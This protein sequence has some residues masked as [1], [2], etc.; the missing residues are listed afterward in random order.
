MSEE[1]K[2]IV[3][4]WHDV[5]DYSDNDLTN[6]LRSYKFDIL[7][8]LSGFTTG[9]RF[10]VLARRCAKIQIEWLG[11]NNSLGAKNIDYLITDKNLIK[12]D[13]HKFYKEKI[14]YLPNIWN[15]SLLQLN[16]LILKRK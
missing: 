3:Y 1:L 4:K 9:N 12:T 2:K 16:Y 10:G 13:E 15:V 8:D 5:E 7:F 6:Y 14:L 11:Y